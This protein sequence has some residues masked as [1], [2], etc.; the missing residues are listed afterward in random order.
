MSIIRSIFHNFISFINCTFFYDLKYSFTCLIVC[1]QTYIHTLLFYIFYFI[2]K[3]NKCILLFILYKH[4]YI[5]NFNKI[6][7]YKYL[8]KNFLNKL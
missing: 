2:Y 1:I 6:T 5:I 4:F 3:L 8:I 7:K